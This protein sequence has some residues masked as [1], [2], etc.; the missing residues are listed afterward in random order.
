MR[1]TSTKF[2]FNQ[3]LSTK[4]IY[5]YLFSNTHTHIYIYILMYTH[6]WNSKPFHSLTPPQMRAKRLSQQTAVGRCCRCN[7]HL[8]QFLSPVTI[9]NRGWNSTVVLGD[10]FLNPP[11]VIPTQPAKLRPLPQP[12]GV[13]L[14]PCPSLWWKGWLRATLPDQLRREVEKWHLWQVDGDGFPRDTVDGKNSGRDVLMELLTTY[15]YRIYIYI[16]MK[17]WLNLGT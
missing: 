14:W 9:Y 2:K 4:C 17:M 10:F 6:F 7:W 15:I 12:V 1:Q 16:Y 13:A 3:H 11:P 5:K 8:R